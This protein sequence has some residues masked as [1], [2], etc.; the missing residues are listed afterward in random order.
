MLIEVKRHTSQAPFTYADLDLRQREISARILKG[1]AGTILLS[2]VAP[3]ITVGRRTPESDVFDKSL[4][5]KT[6][7]GG[8]ATWHGTGQWVLF[9]VEKLEKLTGD[10]RGVYSAVCSLLNI[11]KKVA[12]DYGVASEIKEGEKLGVW[13]NTGKFAAV[14]IHIENRILMHGLSLNGF[15]TN[16]SFSG[17]RPCGL[18]APVS[19]ILD[20]C[21]KIKNLNKTA[22]DAAFV[23]LGSRLILRAKEEFKV[24]S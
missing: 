5:Y 23:E 3:V 11:A 20:E 9:C 17:L 2:E 12:A 18:D 24:S 14:G 10:S 19:Y 1:E 4:I 16:E 21:V 6:D 15:K 8:L 7:R 22:Q 13:S